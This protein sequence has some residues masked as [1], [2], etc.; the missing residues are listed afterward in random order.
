M[1]PFRIAEHFPRFIEQRGHGV[2]VR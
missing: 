2:C 1:A